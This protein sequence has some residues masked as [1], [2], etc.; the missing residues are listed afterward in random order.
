MCGDNYLRG[1]RRHQLNN[2][3]RICVFSIVQNFKRSNSIKL[4]KAVID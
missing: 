4:I 1:V 3:A 2:R